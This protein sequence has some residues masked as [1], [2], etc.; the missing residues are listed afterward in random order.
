MTTDPVYRAS[1]PLVPPDAVQTWTEKLDVPVAVTGGT[2]FV[3]SH[4][5]ETLCAARVPVR[6][7]ARR[8]RPPRWIAGVEVE[9]VEG[10]LSDRDAL[11]RLVDGAGTVF[12]LAGR[13]RATRRGDFDVANR[14]GT[15]ELVD[16]SRRVGNAMFVHVSSQAALGPAPDSAG[17]G[18]EA[19]PAPVSRYGRS[20]LGAEQAVRTFGD[21]RRWAI[22]RPPAIFGPRDTDVFEF[23]RL[24]ARGVV[25]VPAGE[26]WVTV[27]WVGDVVRGL[28]AAATL[29]ER[30][31]HLGCPEPFRLD[32][33]VRAVGSSGGH[34]PR[35]VEVPSVA[36]RLAGAVGAVMRR[37]G[38]D[39][40][41]MTPD[42][43]VELLA[44][45]WTLETASSLAILGLGRQADLPEALRMT[46]SWYRTAGWL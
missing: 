38:A 2:G 3:G 15:E 33:L 46:W 10:D 25:P 36:V 28:L 18:P 16:V 43:A 8:G 30:T 13:L 22:V 39:R 5:V 6:A 14:V 17:L 42:K 27:A 35:V 40:V 45:H 34:E 21:A 23:F 4:L 11:E 7:L 20:K 24:A 19:V 37:F 9:W 1:H 12:H 32:E 44:R 29:C 31:V 41:A 26:R